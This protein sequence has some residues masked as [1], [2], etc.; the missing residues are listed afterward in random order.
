MTYLRFSLLLGVALLTLAGCT[1]FATC[2]SDGLFCGDKA[3]SSDKDP[4]GDKG[5]K[6]LLEWTLKKKDEKDKD[7]EKESAKDEDKNGKD[8]KDED[9]KNGNGKDEDKKNGNGSEKSKE[10]GDDKEPE[11]E[12]RL[13]TDRPHFPEASTAVG[14]GRIILESGYTY[15]GPRSTEYQ[16]L[17]TYPE[18]LLR[19]GLFADW[20]EFRIGQSL[21]SERV[22]VP[23]PP[24]AGPTPPTPTTIT[25]S[26]TGFEDLY[27]GVKLALTEQ[28]KWLPESALILSLT[29]PSG[30]QAFT[31]NA[32]LPGINYDFSWEVIKDRLS[33]EGVV[34][35]AGVTD[36]LNHHYTSIATGLTAV[37]DLTHNLQNFTEWFGIYPY[38]AL[39]PG[40]AGPQ[41]YLVTGFVYFIGKD[42]EIDI[43]A[44]VGLTDHSSDYLAGAGFSVRY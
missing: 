32:V 6:V 11:E 39:D 42:M 33:I 23:D 25:Q 41:H 43:R 35:A 36:E 5:P 15:Y 7:K 26:T 40:L 29:V 4:N 24:A 2:P 44:G 21:A 18:A 10:N 20:F 28:E 8:K 22:R 13:D 31:N 1:P 27:L 12:K 19:I 38:G 16:Q 17:Q 37:T 3:A 14:V 9:K 30:S 34:E